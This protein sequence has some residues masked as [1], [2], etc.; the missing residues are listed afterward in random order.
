MKLGICAIVKDENQYLEEWINYHL[1][2]VD[3]IYIYDN[4]SKEPILPREN[5]TVKLWNDN[6]VGSQMRAYKDLKANCDL[7]LIAFIDVDE[8]ICTN[9]PLKEVLTDLKAYGDYDGLVMSWRMYGSD[10]YFTERQPQESYTKYRNNIHVKSFVNPK[11]LKY[12]PDP[13]FAWV[14]GLYIDEKGKAAFGPFRDHTSD[15][16]WIKH[17]YTRSLPEWKEKILRGSGD[18]VERNKTLEEFFE[19]NDFSSECEK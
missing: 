11:K 8:F 16:I 14:S 19:Y 6:E 4:E 7:D 2:M 13:H 18:K 3:H 9:K 17:I 12:F 5:V 10:P 15:H 1:K